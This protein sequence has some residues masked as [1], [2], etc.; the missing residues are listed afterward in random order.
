MTAT[1]SASGYR[2]APTRHG[3]SLQAI[4]A[5]ELGDAAR[6]VDLV[7]YNGLAPPYIVDNLSDLEGAGDEGRVLLAGANIRV[8]AS[9]RPNAV[10]SPDDVFGTDV[11]L[12]ADGSLSVNASGDYETV[13]D[14]PNLRQALG[15]R[16]STEEGELVRHPSYG[17]P[18][19]GLKGE[20]ASPVNLLYS[21]ALAERTLR[22]DPRVDSM[23]SLETS[24]TGDAV[25]VDA[26]VIATDGRPLPVEGA[27]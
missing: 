16:L 2:L 22:A 7:A 25:L 1:V 14:L 15:I 5:R 24:I 8:P 26:E 19:F 12:G 21:R 9:R 11:L 18:L 20:K 3:D 4:A 17:N 23:K 10:A 6:W 27:A 13:S